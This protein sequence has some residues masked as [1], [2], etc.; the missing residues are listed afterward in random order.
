MTCM[1][2]NYSDTGLPTNEDYINDFISGIDDIPDEC[3][4]NLWQHTK[5]AR[6]ARSVYKSQKL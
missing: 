3:I 5:S 2:K 4:F 1:D 6:A